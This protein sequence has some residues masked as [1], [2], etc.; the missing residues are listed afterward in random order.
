MVMI[1]E[2]PEQ[3]TLLNEIQHTVETANHQAGLALH[4]GHVYCLRTQDDFYKIGVT[5]RLVEQRLKELKTML[6]FDLELVFSVPCDQPYQ[7]E[8]WLHS[9]FGDKRQNGE[10]FKLEVDDL[11]I[12]KALIDQRLANG[13]WPGLS[14]Q[15]ELKQPSSHRSKAKAYT[16]PNPPVFGSKTLSNDGFP[17]FEEWLRDNSGCMLGGSHVS[18]Y[19]NDTD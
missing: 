3:L 12:V 6:P 16:L 19:W 17:T 7:L 11:A 8:R 18:I 10:W 2:V 5:N 15:L 4:S 1:V 13:Q 9:R 14:K